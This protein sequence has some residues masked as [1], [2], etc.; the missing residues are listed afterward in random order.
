MLNT[1]YE[2][3]DRPDSPDPARVAVHSDTGLF[4]EC[5]DV[6]AAYAYLQQRGVPARAPILTGYG[7]EQVY[8]A[9]PDGYGICFQHP[10]RTS[11]AAD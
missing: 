3:P 10:A 9:D 8:L 4:F 11:K 6:D 7:M 2:A 1:A 5:E